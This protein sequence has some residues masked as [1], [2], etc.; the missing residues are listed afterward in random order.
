MVY[1]FFY[2]NTK[3]NEG[4]RKKSHFYGNGTF[5]GDRISH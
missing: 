1:I 5:L 2:D 4:I 3:K